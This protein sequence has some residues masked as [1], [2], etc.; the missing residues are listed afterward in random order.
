LFRSAFVYP[1]SRYQLAIDYSVNSILTLCL[2]ALLFLGSAS[3][4]LA[5]SGTWIAS[6]VDNNWDTPANWSSNTV[7]GGLDTATFKVT[8]H[9]PRRLHRH[10]Q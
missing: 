4:S 8:H 2:C 5:G 6:P 9:L 10:W 7:P 3:V 1:S